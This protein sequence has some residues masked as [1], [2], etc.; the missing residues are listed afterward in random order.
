MTRAGKR[1]KSFIIKCG[2]ISIEKYLD[3]Y[4][5]EHIFYNMLGKKVRIT[6]EEV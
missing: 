4:T 2:F 6:I 3:K 1:K 5:V